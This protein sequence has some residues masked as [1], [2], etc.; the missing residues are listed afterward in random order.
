M[1]LLVFFLLFL[2]SFFLL[3]SLGLPCKS[4]GSKLVNQ[5]Y[6]VFYLNKEVVKASLQFIA[7]G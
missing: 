5:K 4:F 2:N 7:I 3:L 1:G 6:A